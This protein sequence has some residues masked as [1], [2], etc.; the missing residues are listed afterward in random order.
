MR[1]L[2]SDARIGI[3]LFLLLLATLAWLL[4][5]DLLPLLLRYL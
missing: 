4:R 1:P 3:L 2:T 5:K